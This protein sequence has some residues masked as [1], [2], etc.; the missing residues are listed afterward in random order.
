[1]SIYEF[2]WKRIDIRFN[3]K[4]TYDLKQQGQ[5][6][7]NL[8]EKFLNDILDNECSFKV[9]DNNYTVDFNFNFKL[10]IAGKPV[11]GISY[12]M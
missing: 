7:T 6:E 1:M 12:N 10:I 5:T 3:L 4:N 11:Y 8:S 2:K 9:D